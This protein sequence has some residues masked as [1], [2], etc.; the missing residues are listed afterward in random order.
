SSAGI[1][2]SIV[3]QTPTNEVAVGELYSVEEGKM[4]SADGEMVHS[5]EFSVNEASLTGESLSVYKSQETEDRKMYS[6][7]QVVS[8]LAILNVEKIGA[9]TKLG[10]VSQSIQDIKEVHSPLQIQITKFVKGMAIIGVIVFLMVWGF[11]YWK[12]GDIIQSLL[13]GLT[14]AMSVLPEEIPVAFTTFMA[15]G[16]WKLMSEGV[17]IKRSSVV[18]TLGSP[19]VICTD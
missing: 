5:N 14:L 10:K 13:A 1:R 3:M 8:D 16:A 11:S 2:D 15:L 4:V 9:E 6:G 19:T 7:T 18:Q 17:I 12:S